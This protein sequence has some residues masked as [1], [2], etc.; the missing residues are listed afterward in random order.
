MSL[1]FCSKEHHRR[2][3]YVDYAGNLKTKH[4][5]CVFFFLSYALIMRPSNFKD[6]K[7][8]NISLI[9]HGILKLHKLKQ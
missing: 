4:S 9:E 5:S 6:W 2:H 8:R 1:P 3:D 7:E